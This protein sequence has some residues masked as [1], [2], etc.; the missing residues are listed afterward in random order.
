[1][2]DLILELEAIFFESFKHRILG[3]LVFRLDAMN[4]AIDVVVTDGKSFEDVVVPREPLDQ[5][6]LV[7]KTPPAIRAEYASWLPRPSGLRL[8]AKGPSQFIQCNR[9]RRPRSVTE[10]SL[11]RSSGAA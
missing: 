4:L 3:R 8:C 11:G 6:G 9:A 2:G 1:V 5:R 7:G 10:R